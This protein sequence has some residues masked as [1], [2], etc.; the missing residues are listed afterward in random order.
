MKNA[1]IDKIEKNQMKSKLA[2]FRVGDMVRVH[3][4]IVEGNKERIQIFEGMVIAM[5]STGVNETFTVRKLVGGL[6][7]EKKFL[8]HSPRLAGVDVVRSGKVRRAKL[9]YLRE[10][11]GNKALRTKEEEQLADEILATQ[12][13]VRQ[14]IVE[15]EK[16]EK[17]AREKRHEERLKNKEHPPVPLKSDPAKATDSPAK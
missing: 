16:A 14:H 8:R 7:V 12:E 4:K 15:E 6:G 9:Y 5:D 2:P 1:I 11:I 3:A 13:E 17:E 10:R